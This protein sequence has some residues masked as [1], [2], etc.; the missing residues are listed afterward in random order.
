MISPVSMPASM[1]MNVAPTSSGSL[2]TS[3]QKLVPL[4]R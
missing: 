4:P 2:L 3:G 1:Y